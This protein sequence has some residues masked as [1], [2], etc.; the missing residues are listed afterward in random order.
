LGGAVSRSLV[1]VNSGLEQ[2]VVERVGVDN[3]ELDDRTGGGGGGRRAA[4][5]MLVP[6][7]VAGCNAEL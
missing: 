3:D 7:H 6:T 5:I 2:R 4:S 1:V